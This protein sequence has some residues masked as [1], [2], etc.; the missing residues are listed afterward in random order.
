MKYACSTSRCSLQGI[1]FATAGK[2]PRC[3]QA[4]GQATVQDPNLDIRGDRIEPDP[5]K[6]STKLC[7]YKALAKAQSADPGGG[8]WQDIIKET[9]SLRYSHRVAFDEDGWAPALAEFYSFDRVASG[10][11]Q[12]KV[13]DTCKEWHAAKSRGK[14]KPHTT[15]YFVIARENAAKNT[16]GHALY[17]Q[18]VEDRAGQSFKV[19]DN[20]NASQTDR[21]ASKFIHSLFDVFGRT[22]EATDVSR[23]KKPEDKKSLL[24]EES[25]T[26][27]DRLQ[28]NQN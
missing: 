10:I 28:R 18:F 4:R 9:S 22:Q 14:P 25:M 23:R 19:V 7:F 27:L 12:N 11:E 24:S 15:Q 8:A 5:I 21:I 13:L 17:I 3:G 1:P 20:E 6:D 26:A 16:N 2:C